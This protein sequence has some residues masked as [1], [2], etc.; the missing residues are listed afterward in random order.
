M[1]T[2]QYSFFSIHRYPFYPG[3]G[4]ENEKGSGNGVGYT[5]NVPLSYGIES[6]EYIS[7]F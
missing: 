5:I 1:K 2:P 3:S 4:S 6:D 7:R